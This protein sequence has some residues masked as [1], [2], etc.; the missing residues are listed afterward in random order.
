[1]NK[2][3]VI[4]PY[5]KI[6]FFDECLKSL[7]DQTNKDFT[8]YI[9]NDNSPYDPIGIINKYSDRLQIIYQK[10][11]DNLGKD[12]LTKQWDRCINISKNEEWIM[13]LGDDDALEVN[14]VDEFYNINENRLKDINLIRLASIEIN[15]KDEKISEIYYN[16]KLELAK[17]FFLRC[18]NGE[19][20]CTLTE[21]FFRR[22][23]YLKYGFKNFPV[24]FGSDNVA[25][26]EF[27]EMGNTLGLNSAIAK[28][29]TSSE[30]LSSIKDRQLGF[31]RVEGYYRYYRY[32]IKNLGSYFTVDEKEFI[33]KKA[34]SRLRIFSRN[35]LE[36]FNFILFMIYNIGFVR[37]LK[38]VKNNRY[39]D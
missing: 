36:A 35:K 39:R 37:S 14:V 5:Y 29:R 18:Q 31:K 15:E 34:Y 28:I 21:Q 4:I 11:D 17:D 33:L 1:M 2:L 13:I 10:F 3:A 25:W 22:T 19:G 32:I 6:T 9:G 30:N 23:A 8:V 20:R 27:P 16:P 12:N 38:I 24:A 7:A 26:L